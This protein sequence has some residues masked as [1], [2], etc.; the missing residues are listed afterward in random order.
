MPTETLLG[1]CHHTKQMQLKDEPAITYP[2]F[3]RYRCLLMK[4]LSLSP[5]PMP[6]ISDSLAG[7]TFTICHL[8][9]LLAAGMCECGEE[10]EGGR[11]G[12]V[13]WKMVKGED[14][15]GYGE[16]GKRRRKEEEGTRIQ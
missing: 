5:G 13:R 15:Q 9:A 10:G 11:R 4:S 1:I 7:C 6:Y 8:V 16:G 14:I 3:S 2:E 12:G